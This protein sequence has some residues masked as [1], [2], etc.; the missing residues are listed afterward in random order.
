MMVQDQ[1]TRAERVRLESLSMS[2]QLGGLPHDE[3][4]LESNQR[5]VEEGKTPTLTVAIVLARAERIE[6]WL[7]KAD[8]QGRN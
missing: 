6:D 7:K 2:L 3:A 8:F 5:L 1:L 4:E